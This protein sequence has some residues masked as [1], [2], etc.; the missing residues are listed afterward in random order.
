MNYPEVKMRVAGSWEEPVPTADF[1]P[2][3]HPKGGW[4]AAVAG[5]VTERLGRA[6]RDIRAKDSVGTSAARSNPDTP[7]GGPDD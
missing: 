2:E 6:D 4:W 5:V 1:P 7:G 3:V